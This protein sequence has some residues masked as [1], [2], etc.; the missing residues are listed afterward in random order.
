MAPSLREGHGSET[1]RRSPLLEKSPSWLEMALPRNQETQSCAP[2]RGL[3][4]RDDA[5]SRRGSATMALYGALWGARV[6]SRPTEAPFLTAMALL[7]HAGGVIPTGD[8]FSRRQAGAVRSRRRRHQ[9]LRRR[10]HR[11]RGRLPCVSQAPFLRPEAS[12]RRHRCHFM[13]RR[14]ELLAP[15]ALFPCDEASSWP[16]M[17]PHGSIVTPPRR[18]VTPPRRGVTP[19]R[20]GGATRTPAQSPHA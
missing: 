16:R 19:P 7:G 12:R 15:E 20:R 9:A 17:A 6:R 18:G 2:G 10:H 11:T 3:W 1:R 8:V 14:T 13:P 5:R 4:R